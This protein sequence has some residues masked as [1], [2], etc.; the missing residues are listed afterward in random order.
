MALSFLV[1]LL[2][3]NGGKHRLSQTELGL[4]P[5][6]ATQFWREAP[7]EW[8]Y[9]AEYSYSLFVQMKEHCLPR[10]QAGRISD[11]EYVRLECD[12]LQNE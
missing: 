2:R 5:S 7:G 8:L 10:G 6:S 11:H 4:D 9:F 12:L 3:A 1:A